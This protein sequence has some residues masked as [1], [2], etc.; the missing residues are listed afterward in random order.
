[1]SVFKEFIVVRLC[2]VSRSFWLFLNLIVSAKL[3]TLL[4]MQVFR[5]PQSW[6]DQMTFTTCGT[7]ELPLAALSS[8]AV[9]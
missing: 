8:L 7:D 4:D 5:W 1:M 9:Y 6:F 3:D 2:R